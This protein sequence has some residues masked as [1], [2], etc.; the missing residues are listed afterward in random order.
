MVERER[1]HGGAHLGAEV[2]GAKPLHADDAPL[3]PDEK[4]DLPPL[5]R[6]PRP[7]Q[8]VVLEHAVPEARI[9]VPGST[10]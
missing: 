2:G 10:E 4:V 6:E 1:E 5:G 7:L 8:P 3:V 9:D